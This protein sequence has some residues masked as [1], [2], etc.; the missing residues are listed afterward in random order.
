MKSTLRIAVRRVETEAE[1]RN[2]LSIL[3]IIYQDEKAWV[4]DAEA[5]FPADDLSRKDISWFIAMRR[6]EPIGVLRVCYD[7]PVQQYLQY[8]LKLIDRDLDIARMIER[9]RIAEIGR[10]AVHPELRGDLLVASRLMGAAT[11]EIVSRQYT[12]LITD[13]FEADPHSPLGFHTRVIGF[14]PIATHE[15]GDLLYKGRRITLVLDVKAAYLRLKRQSNW[16][17]RTMTRGWTDAM[18]KHLAA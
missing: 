17:F 5:Q 10:F 9:E 2:A 16:F 14:R 12:Q 1:R 8:G 4:S 6:S 7:P 15:I 18:H 11:R 3:K 13:V